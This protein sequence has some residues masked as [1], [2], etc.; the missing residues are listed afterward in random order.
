MPDASFN[1]ATF[2]FAPCAPLLTHSP[3]FDLSS[4]VS[5]QTRPLTL[6]GALLTLLTL[7]HRRSLL[8]PAMMPY[9]LLSFAIFLPLLSRPRRA[10]LGLHA[11]G[12]H[13][14]ANT[15]GPTSLPNLASG[16][17]TV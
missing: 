11:L 6:A 9:P 10:F 1:Y 5:W 2:F 16:N 15:A 8:F 4:A 14:S 13:A 12:L 7:Q 3:F 17:R